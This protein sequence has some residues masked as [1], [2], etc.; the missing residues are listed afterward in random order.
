METI[1]ERLNRYNSTHTKQSVTLC[2][3]ALYATFT[4]AWAL[5]LKDGSKQME[6]LLYAIMFLIIA[7]ITF[8]AFYNYGIA[9][10]ARKLQEDLIADEISEDSAV[11]IM[12]KKSV[13]SFR[14]LK[15][16]LFTALFIIC[17]L[18]VYVIFNFVI[19]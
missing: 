15:Y 7:Y 14:V 6:F 10:V 9:K 16:K 4:A 13:A 8:E 1:K 5:M 2:R 18:S 3:H 17:C 12:N 19:K 11:R